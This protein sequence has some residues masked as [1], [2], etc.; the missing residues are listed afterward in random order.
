VLFIENGPDMGSGPGTRKSE[1]HSTLTSLYESADISAV[2][3]DGLYSRSQ[4]F[5]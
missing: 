2:E 1:G 4:Y 3:S 5:P